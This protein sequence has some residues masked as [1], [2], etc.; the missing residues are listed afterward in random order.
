VDWERES[1][2]LAIGTDTRADPMAPTFPAVVSLPAVAAEEPD[3][4]DFFLE[5]ATSMGGGTWLSDLGGTGR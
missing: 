3:P 5:E 4:L 2:Q 1:N